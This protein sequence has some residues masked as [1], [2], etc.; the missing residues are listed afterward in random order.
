MARRNLD[1]LA[2]F[3]ADLDDLEQ[4]GGLPALFTRRP[5]DQ[6]VVGTETELSTD[7][8]MELERCEQI[9]ERG[10][11]TFFEVGAA[12]VRVRDLKLYRVEHRTFEAYCQERW[13]IERRQAYRLMD[14]TEVVENVSNWTQT[15]PTN[16]AQARPLTRLKEPEQQREA[17]RR[18]VETAPDER[19]TAAH[20]ERVVKELLRE[21]ESAQDSAP[22]IIGHEPVIGEPAPPAE[23]P[24]AREDFAALRAENAELRQ[25]LASVQ[26]ILEEYR[27]QITQAQGYKPHSDRGE[28]VSPLLRAL[29]RIL[30]EVQETRRAHQ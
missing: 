30:V 21:L 26:T 2:G 7:E 8:V 6:I 3:N 13:G 23:E 24:A 15:L 22:H 14:A 4:G 12:L 27:G 17:W 1:K 18:A 20:V 29:E 5:A 25:R 11:K 19:I 9:I 16:E 10:L 28:A